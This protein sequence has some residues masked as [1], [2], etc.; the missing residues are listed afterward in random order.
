MSS[1]S[2]FSLLKAELLNKESGL[3]HTKHASVFFP[4]VLS[5]LPSS[6]VSVEQLLGNSVFYLKLSP[7]KFQFIFLF[8]DA[9]HSCDIL[10]QLLPFTQMS[11]SAKIPSRDL[12]LLIVRSC[13]PSASYFCFFLSYYVLFFFIF[14]FPFLAS[15]I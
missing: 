11:E 3:N 1:S 14:S 7:P 12:P 2:C 5:Y 9:G 10:S 8:I 4:K 13:F 15:T 6:D